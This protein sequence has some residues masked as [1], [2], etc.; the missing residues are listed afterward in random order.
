M[1]L[2]SQLLESRFSLDDLTAS[3]LMTA[4]P[5]SIREDATL[6]EAIRFMTDHALSGAVVINAAGRPVGVITNTDILVH[7]RECLPGREMPLIPMSEWT[8]EN[9]LP[10]D[11][12]A[13][14]PYVGQ[15]MTP[16]VFT[17]RSDDS[18]RKVVEQMA[19][20]NIHRLFVVDEVSV[21]IGVISA[22]DVLRRIV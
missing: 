17:V 1:R 22:L 14:R 7:Q 11:S 9:E 10:E 2:A 15:V 5:L 6:A 21:V 12:A 4:N 16:I 3:D 13:G 18:A 20:L 19:A 8:A